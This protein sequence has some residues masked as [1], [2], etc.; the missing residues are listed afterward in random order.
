MQ[1][2]TRARQRVGVWEGATFPQCPIN[3]QS[4]VCHYGKLYGSPAS[5]TE[6]L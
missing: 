5:A 2:S 6:I 1:N 4:Q 3:T